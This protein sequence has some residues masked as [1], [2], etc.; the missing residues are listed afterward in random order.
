MKQF[1]LEIPVSSQPEK[2]APARTELFRVLI[3]GEPREFGGTWP[4]FDDVGE[5]SAYVFQCADVIEAWIES[6]GRARG[7][8]IL[9]VL[10]ADAQGNPLLAIPL[11]IETH[12]GFRVLSF[13][14]AAVSD[15]NAPIIYPGWYRRAATFSEIWRKLLDLLPGFDIL[16][17]TKMPS[18]IDHAE[19]P[20]L[21]LAVAEGIVSSHCA[22]LPATPEAAAKRVPPQA[23]TTRRKQRRLSE[24]GKLSFLVAT[25]AADRERVLDSVIRQKRRKYVDTR[26]FDGFERPGFRDYYVE[27]TRHSGPNGPVHLSALTIDDRIIASHWGL[28][29][30]DRFYSLMPAFDSDPHWARYSP[31]RILLEDLIAWSI[32]NGFKTFDFGVGDEPYKD[33]YCE[34][35]I[36]LYD[37]VAPGSLRGSLVVVAGKGVNRLRRTAPWR[38]F[39]DSAAGRLVRRLLKR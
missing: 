33:E 29:M 38:V 23:K 37:H 13:L 1:E 35:T 2:G 25:T 17:L 31:G 15:Y 36:P 10:I 27:L 30:G 11:G 26:G 12:Y 20:M 28:T 7:T 18:H 6:F 21:D 39:K 19:N 24:L 14:D 34:E 8:E 16:F 32:K 9:L 3:A 22:I 5:V 4:R